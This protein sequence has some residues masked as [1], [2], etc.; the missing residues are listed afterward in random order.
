MTAGLQHRR[1]VPMRSIGA[2]CTTT[3]SRP[4]RA[5][6]GTRRLRRGAS[7]AA[8]VACRPRHRGRL[9]LRPIWLTRERARRTGRLRS[10][11]RHAVRAY[12]RPALPRESWA[13]RGMGPHP[14]GR[15]R[16]PTATA[17]AGGWCVGGGRGMSRVEKP[18]P[19]DPVERFA[20]KSRESERDGRTGAPSTRV[21]EG[22]RRGRQTRRSRR[23]G[24]DAA[25]RTLDDAIHSRAR[26]VEQGRC[27][28]RRRSVP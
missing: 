23:R 7:R 25:R 5:P 8:A 2:M 24:L 9:R 11:H 19:Q 22:P 16:C 15:V 10:Q 20:T 18:E 14:C 3:T 27:R 26:R 1:R 4:S 6:N 21:T 17:E 12:T 28:R 13:R